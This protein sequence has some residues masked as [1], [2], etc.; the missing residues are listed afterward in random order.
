MEPD[1]KRKLVLDSAVDVDG[2][3]KLTCEKALEL[4]RKNDIS[5]KE[6]GEICDAEE[7][8]ITNC[9]LGCFQ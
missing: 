9:Q 4:S 5:L 7:V 2:R 3:K 1:Q 8:K 6:I